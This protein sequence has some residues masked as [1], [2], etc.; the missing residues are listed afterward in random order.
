M[1]SFDAYRSQW[2]GNVRGDLLA[3]T[4]RGA[5][6]HPRGDRLL[7]HRGRR[8]EGGAL[9]EF[10]IA[11]ITAIAGRAA[12]HDLGGDGG[13][14]GADGDARARPR[15]AIP[16]GRHRARGADSRS[17]CGMLRLG[18]VMRYVSKSVMTGFVNALAILIF[19]AQLPELDPREVPWLTYALVAAGLGDHLPLPAADEGRALAAGHDRRADGADGGLRLDVR[20]VGDMGELPD[21]LPMFLIP[22]I[23][24]NLETLAIILPYSVA[25]AVGGPA[26]KPDDP[27]HRRRPD[28]HEVE[29][30]P[31]M[32]GPGPR[33]HRHRLHRRHGGLRHDRAVDH[34]R[35]VGRARAVVVLRGGGVP[36]DPGRRLGDW[37]ASSRCRRSWR[38]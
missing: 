2:L 32:R 13:H 34:Q 5:G 4:G 21:T 3:G 9:R 7:D 29:P 20:T 8:P 35:E 31:G 38:S 24:L 1:F 6:A 19:M 25:V 10:S 15:A 12:R 33:Q 14:G 26:G 18:F 23:P 36:A 16:A 37:S 17:P 27:E 11:V 22:D 28:R 30:E